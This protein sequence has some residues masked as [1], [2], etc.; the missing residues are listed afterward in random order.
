ML[1]RCLQL[2]QSLHLLHGEPWV[3]ECGELLLL[4]LSQQALHHS[5]LSQL[6]HSWLKSVKMVSLEGESGFPLE[7]V[8]QLSAQSICLVVSRQQVLL[9]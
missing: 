8:V 5:G 2:M 3:G 4:H 9:T 7:S 1:E 6:Q